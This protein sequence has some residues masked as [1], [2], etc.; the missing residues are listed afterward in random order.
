MYRC[1]VCREL[2]RSEDDPA[3]DDSG[4]IVHEDCAD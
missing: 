1:P 4:R 3:I 2:V